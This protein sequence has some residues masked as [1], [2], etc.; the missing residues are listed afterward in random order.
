MYNQ[1]KFQSNDRWRR[2]DHNDENFVKNRT[3]YIICIRSYPVHWITH[4]QT[5][6]ALCMMDALLFTHQAS[7]SI[8]F[9]V[10]DQQFIIQS[11]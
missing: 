10:K 5:R 2:E 4:M 11:M 6:I 1:K 8:S 3:G 9:T 7:D